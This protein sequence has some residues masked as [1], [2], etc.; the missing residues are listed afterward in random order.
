MSLDRFFNGC[1]LVIMLGIAG[2]YTWGL[3]LALYGGTVT[4]TSKSGARLVFQLS[5]NPIG[6]WSEAT[7][8]LLMAGFFWWAAYWIW[9]ARIQADRG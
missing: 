7:I 5:Q 2:I 3:G 9:R 4:R 8:Q 1:C 6:F